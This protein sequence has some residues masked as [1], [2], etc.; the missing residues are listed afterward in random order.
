VTV[1]PHL[2][3]HK[4]SATTAFLVPLHVSVR[5]LGTQRAQT[6]EQQ[7]SLISALHY[8]YQRIAG[9]QLICFYVMVTVY[10]FMKLA[11]VVR[12]QCSVSA[13]DLLWSVMKCC[14][15]CLSVFTPS[16]LSSS[17]CHNHTSL[18]MH[19]QQMFM[20]ASQLLTLSSHKCYHCSLFQ[21]HPHFCQFRIDCGDG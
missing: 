2:Q 10:Q 21:L 9:T 5:I 4:G 1:N 13:T 18:T 17:S 16:Y 7:R 20:N 19:F 11:D 3:C 14:S 12:N 8:L 6:F 15:S